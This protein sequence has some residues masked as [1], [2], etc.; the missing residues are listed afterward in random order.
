MGNSGDRIPAALERKSSWTDQ[1]KAMQSDESPHPKTSTP[2]TGRAPSSLLQPTPTPHKH[3]ASKF[4]FVWLMCPHSHHIPGSSCLHSPRGLQLPS[5][6]GKLPLLKGSSI[7]LLEPL[8]QAQGSLEGIFQ[9]P[10]SPTA[11]ASN[12]IPGSLAFGSASTCLHLQIRFPPPRQE[13]GHTPTE[14]NKTRRNQA[15]E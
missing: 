5:N 6:K 8:M 7:L 3:Q 10:A 1:K 12:P 11:I 2:S 9:Q 4:H 14:T 13:P 15:L